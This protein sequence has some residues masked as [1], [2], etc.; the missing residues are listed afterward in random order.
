VEVVAGAT[1][2]CDVQLPPV[3]AVT[4]RVYGDAGP[5]RDKKLELLKVDEHG[6]PAHQPEF[7]EKIL[8]NPR[9]EA[10]FPML[11]EGRYVPLVGI[12][13][14]GL[15]CGVH[16]VR[17]ENT[18]PIPVRLGSCRVA[19]RILDTRGEPIPEVKLKLESVPDGMGVRCYAARGVDGHF[20]IPYVRKGTYD[21]EVEL[22]TVTSRVSGIRVD[23]RSPSPEI[24]VLLTPM[25][26]VRVLTVDPQGRPCE[27]TAE[28]FEV[29]GR[30]AT[31]GKRALGQTRR[32]SNGPMTPTERS[33][34]RFENLTEGTWRFGVLDHSSSSGFRGEPLEVEVKAYEVTE[35]TLVVED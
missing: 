23:P 8:T 9:G 24:E 15:Q 4:F 31:D 19:V 27:A 20:R 17:G 14:W 33:E 10:H 35:V 18:E 29:I 2:K 5:I 7:G 1:A 28:R 22:G 13:R 25:G 16:E 3:T 12:G 6:W 34:V 32:W 21:F 30:R 11:P 26:S